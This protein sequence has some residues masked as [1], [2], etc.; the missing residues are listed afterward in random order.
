MR[1]DISSCESKTKNY[2][3][4]NVNEIEKY[5]RVKSYGGGGL[6]GSDCMP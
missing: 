6:G 1:K 4:P 3:V 2:M 5:E